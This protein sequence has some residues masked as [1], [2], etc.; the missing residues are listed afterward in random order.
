M[1]DFSGNLIQDL[2]GNDSA[3]LTSK[4]VTNNSTADQ[5]TP[6]I[7]TA[8]ADA[9]GLSITLTYDEALSATTATAGM[10]T[11]ANTG[12]YATSV[13]SVA[14]S[15]S[16]VVLTLTSPVGAG[17]TVTVTYT[18]PALVNDASNTAIQ[19]LAGND[20]A[21]FTGRVVTNNSTVDQTAPLIS[22]AV[23]DSTGL[24]ITL[25][26]GE[27]LAAT[28]ASAG[29]F[30]VA[31]TGG[32][33]TSVSS[34][35]VSGSTVVLTLSSPVGAGRTVTVTYAAPTTVNDATNSAIQDVA[36]NDAAALTN[37]AVTNN[38]TVDQTSPVYS[39]SD[40]SA[41]GLRLILTYGEALNAANFPDASAFSVTASGVTV[42]ISGVTISGATVQLTLSSAI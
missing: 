26:Y 31:N 7:S 24:T 20:A 14:V 6:L 32:Y 37:R 5:R 27:A 22:S 29:M 18:A 38:S 42:P 2:S 12:G 11:V 36:G 9:T 13:S 3:T 39:R 19:D 41:D 28:T 23:A 10:F 4:A 16:T 33:A 25:T 34:V 35:A 8:V 17:K 30:T 21:A 1:R 40:V 15:G